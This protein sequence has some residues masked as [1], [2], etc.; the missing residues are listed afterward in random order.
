[1]NKLL[2]GLILIILA[3]CSLLSCSQPVGSLSNTNSD[4]NSGRGGGSLIDGFFIDVFKNNYYLNRPEE[5]RMFRRRS[6]YFRVVGLG[7]LGRIDVNDPDLKIEIFSAPISINSYAIKDILPNQYFEFSVPGNYILRGT[8]NN[9]TD[10]VPIEVFG[11]EPSTGEGSSG[12]G[13]VWLP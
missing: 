2:T 9:M 12:V 6:D 11:S 13:W 7:N 8:Y 1:M 10:E 4:S 5:E 3:L